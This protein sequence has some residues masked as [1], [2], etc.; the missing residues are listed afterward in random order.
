MR[1]FRLTI[2]VLVLLGAGYA[3]L[4]F[5]AEPPLV[6]RRALS[7]APRAATA[8]VSFS[9]PEPRQ[10]NP[11]S[12]REGV[13]RTGQK[14]PN[15]MP[16]ELDR[17]TAALQEGRVEEAR[18]L[19]LEVLKARPDNLTSLNLLAQLFRHRLDNPESAALYYQ[20]SLEID[21]DSHNTAGGLRD[22]YSESDRLTEG[23][24]AFRKLAIRHPTS[25]YLWSSLG[26]LELE[27]GNPYGAILHLE[28][29]SQVGPNLYPNQMTLAEAHLA[30]GRP[31]RAIAV[32]RKLLR[33]QRAA[34]HE[35]VKSG[36]S[37]EIIETLIGRTL[38]RIRELGG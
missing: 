9:L 3:V 7:S 30:T 34:R 2:E 21:P 31:D 18:D 25:A 6:K 12:W 4:N 8:P 5:R 36:E 29:A 28:K 24:E 35:L 13:C 27:E 32:L 14:D 22:L 17:I 26:E 38:D 19:L 20:R 15:C 10:R 37:P 1:R 11:S 23:V 33:N 16:E